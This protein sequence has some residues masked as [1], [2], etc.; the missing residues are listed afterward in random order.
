M[1]VKP[2][3]SFPN[4]PSGLVTVTFHAP[5]SAYDGMTNTQVILDAETAWTVDPVIYDVPRTS[6]T[7][8]P[9]RK[10]APVREVMFTVAPIIPEFGVML[11]TVGAGNRVVVVVG[12]GV[13]VNA[14]VIVAVITGTSSNELT[15]AIFDG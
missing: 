5:A 14:A 1:T 6:L 9:V 11:S 10:L 4:C 12:I 13:V 15:C 2:L 3:I 8:A 7:V